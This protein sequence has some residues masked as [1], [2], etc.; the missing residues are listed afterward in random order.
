MTLT[1]CVHDWSAI[2]LISSIEKS[3][4]PAENC[5]SIK[6]N[7]AIVSVPEFQL[8]ETY[9][10]EQT[11]DKAVKDPIETSFTF[12]KTIA[13]FPAEIVWIR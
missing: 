6:Q 9:V 8:Y 12:V 10:D 4:P 13:S 1:D 3:F 5:W 2:N 11:W 7:S